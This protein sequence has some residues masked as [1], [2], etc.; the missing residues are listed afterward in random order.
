MNCTRNYFYQISD[1]GKS[2]II[3]T[4]W[5]FETNRMNQLGYISKRE[6]SVAYLDFEFKMPN[7]V[8][9]RKEKAGLDEIFDSIR[10]YL[11][12]DDIIALSV[13]LFNWRGIF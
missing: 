10:D 7:G 1:D 2:V 4:T 8:V 12:K 13:F 9:A 3:G 5:D 6:D 11:S